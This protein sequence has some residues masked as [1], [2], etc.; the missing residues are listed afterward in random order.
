[1][2]GQVGAGLAVVLAGAKAMIAAAMT[3]AIMKA[4]G[5][6]VGLLV[7]RRLGLPVVGAAVDRKAAAA[8]MTWT[9]KF[10]SKSY[11]Y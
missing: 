6:L 10:R 7:G 11:A 5:L 8:A 4:A 9:M 1:M 2:A 3:A